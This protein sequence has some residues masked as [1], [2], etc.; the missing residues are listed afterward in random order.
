MP[1]S[2]PPLDAG[3]D[4][5]FVERLAKNWNQI[6]NGNLVHITLAYL[7]LP[8]LI[9]L[10]GWLKLIY[11]LPL[12]VAM[13][14]LLV[15][16]GGEIKAEFRP[17]RRS[18]VICGVIALLWTGITGAGIGFQTADWFKHDAMLKALTFLDWPVSL[19]PDASLVYVL[20]F[21]LPSAA[22]GK[23]F[24]YIGTNLFLFAWAVFGFMLALLWFVHHVKGKTG[25]VALLFIV[26]AGM[27]IVTYWFQY[28]FGF[29]QVRTDAES[30]AGWLP[31]WGM[32]VGIFQAPQHTLPAYLGASLFWKLKDEDGFYK[33]CC[34]LV[35]MVF[36]WSV[37]SSMGLAL[38]ILAWCVLN[39][40]YIPKL[41]SPVRQVIGGLLALPLL[42]FL[43]SSHFSVVTG[44]FFAEVVEKS[45]LGYLGYL[46]AEFGVVAALAIPLAPRH[47]RRMLIA[48]VVLLV[49]IPVYKV[50]KFHDL[51]SQALNPALFIFWCLVFYSCLHSRLR[52]T[53][54]RRLVALVA[55]CVLLGAANAVAYV[56]SALAD[57]S[58]PVSS[59]ERVFTIGNILDPGDGRQY[60]GRT[61]SLFFKYLSSLAQE[62]DNPEWLHQGAAYHANIG[63]VEEALS[64]FD[65]AIA[66]N[67]DNPQLHYDKAIFLIRRGRAEEGVRGLLQVNA[68]DPS[69]M[70]AYAAPFEKNRW[71]LMLF[72]HM[73]FLT[74]TDPG[75]AQNHYY[76]G[77]GLFIRGNYEAAEKSFLRALEIA[78]NHRQARAYLRQIRAR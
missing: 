17:T 37:G 15:Y 21:Y 66:L 20:G 9:F 62:P 70:A 25:L 63:H 57:Y 3:A 1:E 52:K 61:D 42:L 5:G 31:Y 34:L 30:H 65:S 54:R 32:G 74:L 71:W 72:E 44:F 39:R 55:V 10:L 38:L 50:G 33:T 68:I 28:S 47:Y 22:F 36:C 75:N 67:P 18:V 56:R 40:R 48:I 8:L 29:P 27:D 64:M 45:W 41:F 24:G 7:A 2:A 26:V 46:V 78:P 58:I 13:V 69:Y 23:V 59:P 60:F 73:Y 11:A 16:W 77:V 76:F 4:S 53:V 35:A 43:S 14:A 12:A 19:G 6:R 49:L 51:S